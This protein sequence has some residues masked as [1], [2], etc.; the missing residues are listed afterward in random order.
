LF[1]QGYPRTFL[2]NKGKG[3]IRTYGQIQTEISIQGC[4]KVPCF[5]DGNKIT[6]LQNKSMKMIIVHLDPI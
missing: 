1:D 2:Q 6:N 5:P 3:S 4:D